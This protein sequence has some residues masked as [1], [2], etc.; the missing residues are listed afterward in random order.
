MRRA[1]SKSR[2]RTTTEA[3]YEEIHHRPTNR[4]SFFTQREEQHSGYE[5]AD[6]LLSVGAAPHYYND[7]S[8][9]GPN[10][11]EQQITPENY[12]D[13]ITVG[14]RSR[15]TENYDDVIIVRQFSNDKADCVQEEYDDVKNVREYMSDMFDYDDVGEEPG[16]QGGTL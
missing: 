3:V 14:L 7:I 11:E 9:E 2:H 1:L 12:D 8:T 6:E 5:D 4:Q 13:I 16:K 10:E 15:D